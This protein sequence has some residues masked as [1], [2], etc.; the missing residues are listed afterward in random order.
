MTTFDGGIEAPVGLSSLLGCGGDLPDAACWGSAGAALGHELAHA[1]DPVE[2]GRHAV[3]QQACLASELSRHQGP[4]GAS[5]AGGGVLSEAL[6]DLAGARAANRASQRAG[7]SPGIGR[8]TGDQAFFYAF[9]RMHCGRE[10]PGVSSL[11]AY[12]PPRVRVNAT[13]RHMPEFASAFSCQ[14]GAQ[15]VASSVCTER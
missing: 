8:W 15:M 7:A 4:R 11:T 2:A 5:L 10:G 1:A 9:A 14:A 13:L 6:A 3:E 12:P